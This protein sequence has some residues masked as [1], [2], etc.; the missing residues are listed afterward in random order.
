MKY[1]VD[2]ASGGMIYLPIF[3]NNDSGIH[4]LLGLDTNTDSKINS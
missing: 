2:M 3:I 4:N 1:A